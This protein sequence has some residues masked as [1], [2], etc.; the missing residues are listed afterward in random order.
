MSSIDDVYHQYFFGEISDSE[1]K[2]ILMKN[3]Q[4][5]FLLKY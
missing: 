1:N 5:W 2:V 3:S 4:V